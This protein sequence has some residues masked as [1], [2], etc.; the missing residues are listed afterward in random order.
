MRLTSKIILVVAV[1]CLGA[2]SFAQGR[3][4]GMR[5]GMRM[6]SS[7]VFLLNREDVQRDLKLSA[8]QK[9]ELATLREEMMGGFGR[10]GGGQGGGGQAGGTGRPDRG[11]A[12]TGGQARGGGQG[13][14]GFDMEAMQKRMEDMEKKAMAILNEDQ[15]KRIKQIHLQ[16]QG[17]RALFEE[18]LQKEL[19]LTVDQ[20]K[21]LLALEEKMDAANQAVFMRVQSGE[22]DRTEIRAIMENNNKILGEEAEKLLD[23]D[24]KKQ[25][26]EMK[27]PEFKADPRPDRG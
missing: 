13:R 10:R 18:K 17:G 24:Q 1:L 3:G 21:G 4:G 8:E 5:G 9:T 23:E 22:I 16:L 12:R 27:G 20:R 7:P 19:K 26:K 11:G 6:M 25:L 2:M 15:Q 14:G